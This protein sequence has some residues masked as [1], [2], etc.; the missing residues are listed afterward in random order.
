MFARPETVALLQAQIP[1]L[2]A[3][4]ADELADELGDLPLAAAQ[5][6]A[7]LDETRMPPAD[8]LRLFRS[9][10]R[11][12][13]AKGGVIGYQGRIDTAWTLSMERLQA[14]A[15][16]DA[17]GA[18]GLGGSRARVP[19]GLGGSRFGVGHPLQ[20]IYGP[21]SADLPARP[22]ELTGSPQRRCA[23]LMQGHFRAD[24]GMRG[25]RLD[26][27]A[28]GNTPRSPDSPVWSGQLDVRTGPVRRGPVPARTGGEPPKARREEGAL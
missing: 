15:G 7:Y 13:L 26:G 24:K 19:A 17:G 23:S 12:M 6:A 3:G 22:A 4:L 14:G 27:V 25:D 2:E 21:P 9:R 20:V 16:G 28:G 10:R 18:A 11:E 5:A 8:Y 1:G